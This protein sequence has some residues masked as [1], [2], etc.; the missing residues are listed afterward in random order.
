MPDNALYSLRDQLM[1]LDREERKNLLA[2][3]ELEENR[4]GFQPGR[5]DTELWTVLQTLSPPQAS[6]HRSLAQFLGDKRAG[7]GR[8]QWADAV[9]TVY[10]FC[11]QAQP[12]RRPVVDHAALA[13]LVLGCLVS[14]MRRRSVSVTP[15]S[16]IEELPR[17]RVAVDRAYPGYLDAG[18]L[19][20][21]IRVTA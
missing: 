4:A 1:E 16:I 20:M 14:D 17:L 7:V 6:P 8:G 2:M 3:V 13:E 19:H 10:A 12:V 15:K 5:E 11:A 21:L 9:K 18:M